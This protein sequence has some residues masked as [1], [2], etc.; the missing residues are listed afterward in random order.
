MLQIKASA[1]ANAQFGITDGLAHKVIRVSHDGRDL[2]NMQARFEEL[3]VM[4]TSG[5]FVS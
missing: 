2:Q 5:N 1:T 4:D 3:A